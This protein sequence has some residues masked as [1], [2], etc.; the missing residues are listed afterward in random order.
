MAVAPDPNAGDGD[1]DSGGGIG[2]S[3]VKEIVAG[4]IASGIATVLVTIVDQFR[5]AGAQVRSEAVTIGLTLEDGA[6]S[7]AGTLLNDVIAVPFDVVETVA[8]SA[9]PLA[10]LVAPVAWALAAAVIAGVLWTLW[11]V[12]PWL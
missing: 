12:L 9:G 7:I 11:R 4:F 3:K 5:K 10:P 1:D 8:A 2:V 6:A